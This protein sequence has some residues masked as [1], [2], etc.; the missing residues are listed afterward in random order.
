MPKELRFY[1][2]YFRP[3]FHSSLLSSESRHFRFA[4]YK[5][6]IPK[7]GSRIWWRNWI[8]R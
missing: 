7:H 2:W 3:D 5:R 1:E 4:R 6:A 8:W